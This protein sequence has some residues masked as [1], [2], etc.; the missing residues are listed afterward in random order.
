MSLGA[1]TTGRRFP[2]WK[3]CLASLRD[4]CDALYLRFDKRTG[5]S[6]MLK[7]LDAVCGDKLKDVLVSET[8]WNRWNWREEML[9][10][11][12]SVKPHIVLVPDQDEEFEDTLLDELPS[13]AA[14]PKMGMMFEYV[15]PM[16]TEDGVVV[17]GGKAYPENRH[18]KAFKWRPNLTFHP[19]HTLAQVTQYCRPGSHFL[20]K[21]RIRHYS[22]YTTELRRERMLKR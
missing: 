18:M 16:P 14:S 1:S 21:T 12:D 10:M 5:D 13:F 15:A 19:Y 4:K 22:H 9:R 3:K 8:R 2:F 11:L 6:Q 20:A 17:L 7:E